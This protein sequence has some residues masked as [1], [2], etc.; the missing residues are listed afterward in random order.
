MVQLSANR[1]LV[2]GTFT[3]NIFTP[4]NTAATVSV[5]TSAQDEATEGGTF[6]GV[7]N[8]GIVPAPRGKLCCF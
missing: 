6:E 1:K 7:G 8:E 4:A 2:Y 3:L 5:P